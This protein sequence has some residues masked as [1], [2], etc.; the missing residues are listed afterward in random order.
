MF[1]FNYNNREINRQIF[2]IIEESD[3][4][5]MSELNKPLRSDE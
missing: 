5:K 3:Y 4:R 1:V 2:I